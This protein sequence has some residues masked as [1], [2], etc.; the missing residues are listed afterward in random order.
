M[1]KLFHDFLFNAKY[2]LEGEGEGKTN[3]QGEGCA[4]SEIPVQD[5]L[6]ENTQDKKHACAD[7]GKVFG[8]KYHLNRHAT[9]H[10]G[11]S[12]PCD[13]CGSTFKRK[14]G[15][16]L[17]MSKVHDRSLIEE[18]QEVSINVKVE[19]DEGVNVS[20][21]AIERESLEE[22]NAE[23]TLYRDSV[24]NDAEE[25]LLV[26]SEMELGDNLIAAAIV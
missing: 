6:V 10:S 12:Y 9:T 23:H 1:V 21:H 20:P 7:C 24:N 13:A 2:T 8:S 18:H 3:F 26:E 5:E 22:A 25:S 11:L 17:H 15:L 16:S 19:K 14:E 4:F